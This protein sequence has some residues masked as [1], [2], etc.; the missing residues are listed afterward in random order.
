MPSVVAEMPCVV[1]INVLASRRMFRFRNTGMV[2]PGNAMVFDNAE[3]HSLVGWGVVPTVHVMRD[4]KPV[5][6]SSGS[7]WY[8]PDF[9]VERDPS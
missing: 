8:G 2:I 3:F 9:H 7:P 5:T 4:V 6:T 1:T